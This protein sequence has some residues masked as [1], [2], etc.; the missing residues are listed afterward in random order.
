MLEQ[1][2]DAI[3]RKDYRSAG[4][5]LKQLKE[6]QPDNP[7]VNFYVARF[8]EAKGKLI[9]AD[10]LYRQLLR[11]TTNPKIMSK[12]RQGIARLEAIEQDKREKALA[13]AKSEPG[14]Q[15]LGALILEPIAAELKKKAAQE[16]ARIMQIDAYSA[17]LQLPSRHWRLYRTGYIGEL[18][19]YASSLKKVN[20]PCFCIPIKEIGKIHVYRVNYLDSIVPQLTVFCHNENEQMGTFSFDWSEVSQRVEGLLPLFESTWDMD[21]KRNIYRTTKTLDYAKF[22]DLHLP[23]RKSILRLCDQ[24]YEF[25]QGITFFPEMESRE[26]IGQT[27]INKN[28][29]NLINFLNQNLTETPIWSDFT[30]FAETAIDFKEMLK[31]IKPHIDLYRR[32]ETPWDA[33]FQLYSGLVF[34]EKNSSQ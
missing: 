33:A 18:K 9:A 24:T 7:W 3:K 6:E 21:A 13:Q 32:Q 23:E 4:Q 1:V 2:A 16:F 12:A 26:P 27:T 8:Y 5:L 20:I 11:D 22:C 14:S 19:F 17:R 34:L 31:Q 29:H 28:W 10:S 30:S 15:E 25:Q